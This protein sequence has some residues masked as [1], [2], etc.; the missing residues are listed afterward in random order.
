MTN[1]AEPTMIIQNL[2]D[3]H[4]PNERDDEVKKHLY[5]LFVVGDDGNPT[6]EP[7]RFTSGRETRGIAVIEEAGG[8]KTTAI[9]T[10]LKEAEF[11]ADDTETGCPRYL[12]IEVPSP[13]TLK[14]VGL[15]I[16]EK[17]GME[18]VSPNAKEWEI[19]K[20]VRQRL[21]V[22][23]VSVLWLDE[24]QDLILARN[25]NDTENTLRMIKSLMQGKDAVIPILSGTQ[26][27][28]EVTAMDPQ[29][30]RR[31][32]KIMP[33]D[34]QHGI[35]ESNLCHLIESYCSEAGIDTRLDGDLVSR[36]ITGSRHR[37]GRAIEMIIN[38][39]ECAV[40]DG[41]KFLTQNHF[42]EAWAMHEGCEPKN[43]IFYSEN[44]VSIELD[45]GAEEYEAARIKRQK[46]KLERV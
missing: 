3:M 16:L 43:N 2:R 23:G 41:S 46:K 29:V 44:W 1:F 30:S 35:D 45:K 24:A 22:L 6:P 33:L 34:L 21:G 9:R 17:T 42:A 15:A 12:E 39:I 14:S 20:V 19:W 18:G 5:R 40:W 28:A 32:T 25:A 11:L 13:A 8:G 26:R 37:F 10:V 38:A 27:L 4:V 7:C 31:F 36:L